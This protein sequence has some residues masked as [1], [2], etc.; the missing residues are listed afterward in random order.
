ME[1]VRAPVGYANASP[2][3]STD[4]TGHGVFDCGGFGFLGPA[5]AAGCIAGEGAWYY[6][7]GDST[8]NDDCVTDSNGQCDPYVECNVYDDNAYCPGYNEGFPTCSWNYYLETCNQPTTTGAPSQQPGSGGG[9]DGGGGQENPARPTKPTCD[10]ECQAVRWLHKLQNLSSQAR[11]K[12]AKPITWVASI[13]TGLGVLGPIIGELPGL[14]TGAA[15]E[16]DLEVC[17]DGDPPGDD[18]DEDQCQDEEGAVTMAADEE[19]ESCDQQ[20]EQSCG[21]GA[22][23][24][25]FS[26]TEGGSYLYLAMHLQAGQCV[27]TGAVADLNPAAYTGPKRNKHPDPAG[28]DDLATPRARGHLIAHALGGSDVFAQNFVPMTADANSVMKNI[29]EMPLIK[30]V[31]SGGH[32]FI[33]SEPIYG[34]PASPIPTSVELLAIG[35]VNECYVFNN[36]EQGTHSYC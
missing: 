28:W 1:H 8:G 32:E 10:A 23:G 2:L 36:M 30:A 17:T 6:Y 21:T 20:P 31:K 5:G 19:G 9:N 27:A 7:W 34:N 16:V 22:T 24:T 35:T 25:R 29:G 26:S 12:L 18:S 14:A 13:A 11:D 33:D 3:S 15:C 4:P